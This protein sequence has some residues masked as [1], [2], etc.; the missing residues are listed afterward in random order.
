M[1]SLNKGTLFLICASFQIPS[2]LLV[3]LRK[4]RHGNL[5]LKTNH[6]ILGTNTQLL[7]RNLKTAFPQVLQAAKAPPAYV[8]YCEISV[9]T[10]APAL[11]IHL[12]DALLHNT[13]QIH[14][15]F[16]K[17]ETGFGTQQPPGTREEPIFVFKST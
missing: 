12:R 15:Q 4:P 16:I 6:L 11:S 17:P 5:S 7:L 9:S 13:S 14:R 8:K 3:Y 1:K 10:A 2:I